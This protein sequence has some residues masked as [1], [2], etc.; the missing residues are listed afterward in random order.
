VNSK[1]NERSFIFSLTLDLVHTSISFSEETN[2]TLVQPK[3]RPENGGSFLFQPVGKRRIFTPEQFS[4]EQRLMFQTAHEFTAAEVVPHV[5]ELEAKSSDRMVRLMKQAGELGILANDVPE[6]YG[7]LGGDKVSSMIL[8]EAVSLYAGW[9]ATVMAHNGIG[10]LPIVYFGSPEQKQRYLPKLANAEWIG[11]YALTEPGSGSDALAAKCRAVPTSDGK[12]FL[13]TGTKQ[14]ITNAAW[15]DLFVVFAQLETADGPKFTAFIVERS[16]PGVAI[17]AEEHK[18][19][20]HGS[21]TCPL[22]LEEARVPVGNVLGEV[23]KGHKIA[24]N[25]LNVGR[26]KLGAGSLGGAKN[27]IADGLRYAGERKQFGKSIAEFGAIRKKLAR[28]AAQVY[29]CESMCYRVAGLTDER[30][31]GIASDDPAYDRKV[32]EAVEEYNIE[33][34]ILKVAGSETLAFVADEMLQLHGGY[35]FLEEYAP[36]RVYRD[37]RINRIFE[38]TN[39]V[40]RMLVPGVILKRA[41]AG[42]L[43][44]MQA[45]GESRAPYQAPA[46]PSDAQRVDASKKAIVFALGLAAGRYMQALSEQQEVLEALADAII[47]CYAMDSALGRALQVQAE[48]GDEAAQ[49]HL[50]LARAYIAEAWARVFDALRTVVAHVSADAER[51]D[52]LEQLARFEAVPPYDA[53]GLRDQIATHLIAR[54]KYEL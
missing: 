30:I 1:L 27:L 2:M 42:L 8:A 25:I 53:I 45:F 9:S 15:A 38:G 29:A 23:G 28:A 52:N 14:F 4:D 10:S 39:E 43:P 5:A 11:A 24:F 6:A 36:A 20:L 48:R 16:F 54:G 51:A 19:G 32:V 33:A 46:E 34:S 3:N 35:G 21:S 18:L 44:L 12:Y 17:G 41:L 47:G 22:I 40:N 13:L 37:N 50:T 7:G 31:A 26:W 49:S